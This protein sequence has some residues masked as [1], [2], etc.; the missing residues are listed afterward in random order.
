MDSLFESNLVQNTAFGAVALWQFAASYYKLRAKVEGPSLPAAM[1]LLPMVFHDATVQAIADR[2]RD[3]AL[4]KALAADRTIV[5]GLQQRVQVHVDRTIRSL[6]FAASAG[7]IRLD[8][9]SGVSV[10]P[11]VAVQPFKY[12]SPECQRVLKAADRLGHSLA[13]SGFETCCSLLGVRF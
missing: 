13:L 11:L 6:A 3:G 7:L 9:R 12:A 1:L 4:L 2:N 8:K 5:V 10:V